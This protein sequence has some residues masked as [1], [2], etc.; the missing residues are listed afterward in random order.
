MSALTMRAIPPTPYP[1]N[2]QSSTPKYAAVNMIAAVPR[3]TM[4]KKNFS[5]GSYYTALY[6]KSSLKMF[7][8]I[9][10]NFCLA[11]WIALNGLEWDVAF[12]QNVLDLYVQRSGFVLSL[13]ATIRIVVLN[14]FYEVG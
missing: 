7:E 2:T 13:V 10:Q 8:D 1:S 11:T 14:P 6:G 12:K 3:V 5:I 4:T 9:G